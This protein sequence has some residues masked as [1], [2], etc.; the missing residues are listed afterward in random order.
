MMESIFPVLESWQGWVS[1]NEIDE[2]G[3]WMNSYSKSLE[4]TANLFCPNGEWMR[5]CAPLKRSINWLIWFLP[6]YLCVLCPFFCF[7]LC[8][9][10]LI[11][12]SRVLTIL[13]KWNFSQLE[14]LSFFPLYTIWFFK[15]SVFDSFVLVLRSKFLG[16]HFSLK[17]QLFI[18]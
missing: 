2:K 6:V 16:R 15:K 12:N 5:I 17:I 10:F 1:S 18:Q 14:K 8:S 3:Y 4:T 11:I 7:V 13:A 9:V